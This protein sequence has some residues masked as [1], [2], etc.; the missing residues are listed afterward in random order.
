MNTYGSLLIC[1]LQVT[2]VAAFG[3][4]MCFAVRR[5]LRT[6]AAMPLSAT[7]GSVVLLT[8]CAFSS[9]P[10][11]L[12]RSEPR[13]VG[14]AVTTGET[15]PGTDLPAASAIYSTA[16]AGEWS[17]TMRNTFD[18]FVS[19]TEV[20]AD[21]GHTSL[22]PDAQPMGW[23]W[24]EIFGGFLA[25][26]V[27]IGLVRLLGGLW[28]VR[29]FVRLSRPLT[30]PELLEQVDLI[31]AEMG[32]AQSVQVRECPRLATAATVGWRR[33]VVLLSE[34][35]STWTEAQLRSVLAHEIAH[36]TRGDF[37][38]TVV[39]QVCVVLHF[40]HPLVHWLASRLRLEQ[41]LAADALAA[42]IVGGSRAYLHAIGE[43]ALKQTSESVGWPAH[44]F[45]PTRRT[46]LRRIEM[47]RDLKFLSGT[48]PLALR[49]GAMVGV[50][51]ATLLAI[52]LRPP[53]G[54]ASSVASAAQDEPAK[55]SNNSTSG[56]G[57]AI[58]G[59]AAKA[60]NNSA[61]GFGGTAAQ[62]EPAK[63]SNSPTGGGGNAT[64]FGGTAIQD[65]PA[66]KTL[67]AKPQKVPEKTVLRMKAMYFAAL[68]DGRADDA[69]ALQVALTALGASLPEAKSEAVQTRSLVFGSRQ[70]PEPASE[71]VGLRRYGPLSVRYKVTGENQRTVWGTDVYT[72]DS[73]VSTAAVHAGL[74]KVGESAE[75]VIST[76]GPGKSFTRSDRN[77]VQSSGYGSIDG[78]YSLALATET[79]D[80]PYLG[81]RAALRGN[82]SA[83][84]T[85]NM[86]SGQAPLKPGTSL[87][88]P[89]GGNPKGTVGG[90][91]DGIYS[92]DSSLDA[93]AVHAG[94][95]KV[96]EIGFVKIVIQ[97]G[98]ETYSASNQNGVETVASG[99]NRLSF[100][101]ERLIR[102]ANNDDKVVPVEV[103]T[104]PEKVRIRP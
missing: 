72:D 14:T 78:S 36:I 32:C 86:L 75:I 77:G 43:L 29:G 67:T 100:R 47:L 94:A 56:S 98:E 65:E 93:A 82:E 54:D 27:V 61:S 66:R 33:P 81:S 35:W 10:S 87:I 18:S 16:N 17:E 19:A 38:A 60:G 25:L 23:S 11:W 12:H 70:V 89:L 48:A 73:P 64:G 9:W 4:L 69:Q 57:P 24:R 30:T 95:L 91:G 42:Q 2:L 6:S 53:G 3:L 101:L 21:V 79:T 88:V 104:A 37:M 26:G 74:V 13:V 20:I 63:A 83:Y 80:V 92:A 50:A 96:G 34:S 71:F 76:K 62:D 28:G 97:P 7:L 41:E 22:Q 40:Y 49:W 102:V 44:T 1:G 45:L 39:A 84:L 68:A 55:A 51:A 52:G 59:E 15:E 8:L 5:W 103:R 99:K 90:G 31:R 58:Q 85:L 46:F